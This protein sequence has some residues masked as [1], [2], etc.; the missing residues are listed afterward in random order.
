MNS[1]NIL[2]SLPGADYI[3]LGIQAQQKNVN[4]AYKISLRKSNFHNDVHYTS[5]KSLPAD[6]R[7][8]GR[9][10]QYIPAQTNLFVARFVATRDRQV[11]PNPKK[12][13]LS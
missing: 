7:V 3:S 1:I 4:R 6:H 8:N 13:G 9:S 11:T 10:V 5:A 2:S 12:L